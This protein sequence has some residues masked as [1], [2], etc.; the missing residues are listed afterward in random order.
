VAEVGASIATV[1]TFRVP[2]RWIFVRVETDDGLVGWGESIVPKRADAVEGAVRDLARNIV[3]SDPS[4]IEDLWQRMHR[5]GFFRGG[6]VYAKAVQPV[7]AAV[8][9]AASGD[10]AIPDIT[11]NLQSQLQPLYEQ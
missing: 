10:T 5:G 2:P 9:Q 8:Q 3:N 4:R 1:E 7:M 11:K 6:P